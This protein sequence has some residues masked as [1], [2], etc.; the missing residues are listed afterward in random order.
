MGSVLIEISVAHNDVPID[1]MTSRTS[2]A[3]LSVEDNMMVLKLL[4]DIKSDL[5]VS[6]YSSNVMY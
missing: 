2:T 3:L 4:N 5:I 1:S 6:F